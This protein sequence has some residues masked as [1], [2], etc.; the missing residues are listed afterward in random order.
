MLSKLDCASMRDNS[1]MSAPPASDSAAGQTQVLMEEMLRRGTERLR[2]VSES[3]RLDCELLLAHAL[4]MPR[5][6]LYAR[7]ASVL[8]A[9]CLDRVQSMLED[10]AGGRPVAQIIGRREFFS[11]EFEITADVLTPRPETE[12]LVEVVAGH[13]KTIS[14][15]A[16]CIDLGTGCGAVAIALARSLPAARIA[17]T[18][19]SAAALKVAQRNA[20]RLAPGRIRF[21][22]ACW[23]EAAGHEW[24]FDA[25]AAN[26]PY[27][28]SRL[29]GRAPL[30][31]EP[32]QALDGGADGLQH[33]RAVVGGAPQH[34]APGG[35]LAVEHGADQG[36]AVRRMMSDAGLK[37]PASHRD[38]SGRERVSVA[39]KIAPD[40][41]AG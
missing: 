8:D 7:S 20:A 14:H 41:A 35:M 32:R 19:V 17:A 25:I 31:F 21:V 40:S 34:L 39:Q 28:E 33:L 10:R 6:T 30:R 18:D 11:L 9:E 22:R 24:R 23:Y 5:A 29:C 13:L 36:Q 26:P 38:L 3:P 12:L 37:R 15:D 2:P 16:S 1:S 4:G 27:V